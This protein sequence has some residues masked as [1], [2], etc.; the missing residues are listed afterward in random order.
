MTYKTLD[1]IRAIIEPEAYLAGLRESHSGYKTRLAQ[2]LVEYDL[3]VDS[4]EIPEN[5]RAAALETQL[6]VMRDAVWRMD[7]ITERI[8]AAAD[9]MAPNR[10]ARRR[11]KK[12]AKK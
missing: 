11:A 2:L 1:D 10:A 4:P 3:M 9:G 7:A 8:E 12:E 5:Q 6:R